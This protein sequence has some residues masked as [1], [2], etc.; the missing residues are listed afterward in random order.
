MKRE[1]CVLCTSTEGWCVNDLCIS[2][3]FKWKDLHLNLHLISGTGFRKLVLN[4]DTF[5]N[6]NARFLSSRCKHATVLYEIVRL[7]MGNATITLI[8]LFLPVNCK[9]L[10]LRLFPWKYTTNWCRDTSI[11][12]GT[13]WHSKPS[14]EQAERSCWSKRQVDYN[15]GMDTSSTQYNSTLELEVMI[16]ITISMDN[17]TSTL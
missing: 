8:V 13:A 5:Q 7:Q 15:A 4:T 17:I 11:E 16:F 9:M 14:K 6:C 2:S 12:K 1:L 10:Y 3:F